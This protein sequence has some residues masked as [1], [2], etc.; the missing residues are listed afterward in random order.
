MG[1]L[2]TN[3][4]RL[5]TQETTAIVHSCIYVPLFSTILK[6]KRSPTSTIVNSR[7][8]S[9]LLRPR[10]ARVWILLLLSWPDRVSDTASTT[11]LDLHLLPLVRC[12]L[13][14]L[15][16]LALGSWTQTYLAEVSFSSTA[17]K[18]ATIVMG[19][20]GRNTRRMSTPFGLR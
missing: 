16:L 9:F 3:R 17:C 14:L 13:L 1:Y 6:Q 20:Q 11:Y 18:L 2:N 10:V 15:Q 4:Q 8:W 19:L 5:H 7:L 12:L